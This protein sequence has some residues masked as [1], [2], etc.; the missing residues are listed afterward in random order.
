M[1]YALLLTLPFGLLGLML[2]MD[3]VERPLRQDALS[4]HLLEFLDSARPEEVET[5]VQQ[6]FA[7]ALDSYWRRRH[8]GAPADSGSVHT[9]S[10]DSGSVHGPTGGTRTAA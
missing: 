7:P 8:P 2:A 5:Y 4:E 1:V 10:V 9:A 6:G 3:R